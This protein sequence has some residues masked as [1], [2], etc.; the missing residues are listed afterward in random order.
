MQS[1]ELWAHFPYGE[2]EGPQSLR[3]PMSSFMLTLCLV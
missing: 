1:F 3:D 2:A